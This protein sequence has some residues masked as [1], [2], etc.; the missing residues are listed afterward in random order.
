[1]LKKVDPSVPENQGKPIGEEEAEAMYQDYKQ[2]IFDG[3]GPKEAREFLQ[4]KYKRGRFSVHNILS[5]M[6]EER[7]VE[8]S[9]TLQF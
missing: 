5:K 4:E 8:I 1:M 2:Q 6:L 7:P 3:K 9:N